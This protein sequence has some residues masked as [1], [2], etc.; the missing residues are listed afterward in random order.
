MIST[1]KA[2]KEK[3]NGAVEEKKEVVKD[4]VEKVKN[5]EVKVGSTQVVQVNGETKI[6][7]N[8]ASLKR[9]TAI[10]KQLVGI[11]VREHKANFNDLRGS[12]PKKKWSAAET[13]QFFMALSIFG[14]DFTMIERIFENSGTKR[15]REAIKSKFRKEERQNKAKIDEILSNKQE[16]TLADYERKYG[17][18]NLEIEDDLDEEDKAIFEED[19]ESEEEESREIKEEGTPC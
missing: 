5:E 14:T 11:S 2:N 19:S 13:Q 17:P 16:Y 9:K 10:T 15:N 6:I 12:K 8:N 3:K 4:A 1:R 7:R 18:L